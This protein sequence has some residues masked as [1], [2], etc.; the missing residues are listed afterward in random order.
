[1]YPN[2]FIVE[3]SKCFL[4]NSGKALRPPVATKKYC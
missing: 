1:M 3:F 4:A 2:P